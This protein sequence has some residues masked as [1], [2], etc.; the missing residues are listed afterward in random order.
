MKDLI[1]FNNNTL[2]SP[3]A[4]WFRR[5]GLIE[6]LWILD[7]KHY[8]CRQHNGWPG[9]YKEVVIKGNSI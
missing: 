7:N 6:T 2:I 1:K 9:T 8:I 5:T 3:C 4:H